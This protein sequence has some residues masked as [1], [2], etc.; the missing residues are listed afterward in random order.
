ML[1]CNKTLP[2]PHQEVESTFHF[3]FSS[4]PPSRQI[5]WLFWPTKY[6]RRDTVPGTALNWFDHF[7]FP[8]PGSQ[9]V[10]NVITLRPWC[11]KPSPHREILKNDMPCREKGKRH[12]GTRHLAEE[13]IGREGFPS[14][15]HP[16]HGAC[17]Y[18]TE[19]VMNFWL[20]KLWAKQV[21]LSFGVVS[22]R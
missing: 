4:P 18:P 3:P 17:N 8:P 7:S 2:F 1:S 6:G 20:A 14:P 19:L 16:T 5:F 21:A 22:N 13:V 11:R 12:W 10:K 15:F 9:H